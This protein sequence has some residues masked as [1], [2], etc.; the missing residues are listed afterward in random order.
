MPS[1]VAIRTQMS[2]LKHTI[3]QQQAQL[4]NLENNLLR[5]PRPLP[6]GILNSPP[7]SPDE[8][9]SDPSP[10]FGRSNSHNPSSGSSSPGIKMQ[11]RSSFEILSGLAGP[12]SSLPLPRPNA[13]NVRPSSYMEE[14]PLSI[15]EGIPLTSPSKRVSS[16]TR[17]LSR[18]PVSSVGHARALAE[19]DSGLGSS[20]SSLQL[21]SPS[22]RSSFAPG[23]TTKVLADLQAGVLNAKNALENTKAQLRLSQR[24]VSQ[25]TRQSEDLKEV[26][27]RLR[28][29][30]E[31]LNNVV[32]RKERLLQEVL[33][34]ARK[35]EAE[36]LT[37]KG[38]LK[39]ETTTSK[40]SLREMEAALAEAQMRSQKCEREYVTLRDSLKGLVES[41]KQDHDGLRDEMRKRE[42]KMRREAEEVQ[43]KYVKLIEEVRKE[44]EEEGRGMKEV[45]R[46]K[47]DSLRV[48]KEIEEG[49]K[50]EV[51]RL[52]AEVDR[53]NRESE[54]AIKTA[55]HLAEELAHLR[56]LMR[57]A[58]S[59]E[60]APEAPE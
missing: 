27:E 49:L 24:Q 30:N 20:I 17:T 35:A 53:S 43:K 51:A 60:A 10:S 12:E 37:L 57:T 59:A 58:G 14:S 21:I 16:P 31:G 33:E 26:R 6:P 48:T 11:R 25:L 40:K 8:L 42:E 41:F 47:D 22:R 54:G 3:R 55:K 52:R 18:I 32:A 36:V 15:R 34:R 7:I 38:Q 29:E 28:L 2:T 5:G 9:D 13:N 46:L 4:H 39:T 44:R 56:R 19:E 45:V 23:N 1:T 50:E